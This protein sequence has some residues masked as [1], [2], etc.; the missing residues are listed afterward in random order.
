MLLLA[1]STSPTGFYIGLAGHRAGCRA[2]QAQRQRH[3]R[4]S[5][6]R[7]RRAP[8]CRHSRSS[9]SAS[10]SAALLGPL[11]TAES[12]RILRDCA[13]ASP[14]AAFFMAIGVL[15]FYLTKQY[16]GEAGVRASARPRSRR[17]RTTRTVDRAPEEWLRLVDRRGG[18]G[19]GWFW[20]A[21]VGLIPVDPVQLG[22]GRRLHHRRHGRPVFP[23]LLPDRG[24]NARGAPPRRG[25]G[26]AVHRLRAVFLR[27]RAGRLVS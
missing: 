24:S 21:S 7:G 9:T 8:G 25:A 14:P 3:R 13:P 27:F 26:R 22:A 2:A 23:V 12:H 11:V 16:L 17:Q 18:R 4:G 6:P 1:I 20:S 15:Q 5:L 10:I 19:V